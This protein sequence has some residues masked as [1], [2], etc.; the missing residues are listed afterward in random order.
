MNTHRHIIILLLLVLSAVVA[1]GQTRK[2]QNKP[3]IDLRP[4]HFGIS[5]GLNIQDVE[6]ENVGPQLL[7][8]GTT[9]TVLCEADTWNPGFS[10]G[11]LGDLRL[12]NHFSLRLAPSLHFGSKHLVFRD[13]DDLD[14]GGRPRESTQD[15]KNTYIAMPIEL[16]FAA[17]RFNNYRPYLLAGISP[18]INLTGKD[19]EYVQLKR[20]DTHIELGMGCD[21]YLPFFKLIP[22]LKFCYGLGDVLDRSHADELTDVNKRVYSQ[23]V[24]NAKPSKMFVLS[25]YFE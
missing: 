13:L 10:V 24:A 12:N 20:F 22:E 19:Q 4:M 21:F 18:M 17:E 7:D 14:E 2:P 3:Y 9:R 25:F 1:Q 5:V 15:M 6:F 11:V 23:S 8:D 16:K